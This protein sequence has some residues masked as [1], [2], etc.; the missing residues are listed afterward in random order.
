MSYDIMHDAAQTD[1]FVAQ[2][3]PSLLLEL[4]RL[5]TCHT[6]PCYGRAQLMETSVLPGSAGRSAH[7]MSPC[8]AIGSTHVHTRLLN[9]TINPFRITFD[10]K[11]R[12]SSHSSHARDLTLCQN[13]HKP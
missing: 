9:H 11:I 4:A 7:I 5:V 6:L 8:R 12:L 2:P 3:G 10:M 13:T 1:G